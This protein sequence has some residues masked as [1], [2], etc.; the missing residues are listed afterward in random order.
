VKNSNTLSNLQPHQTFWT[1]RGI[2]RL[3]FFVKSDLARLFRDWAEDL[4]VHQMDAYSKN[5]S[6][7]DLPPYI[8]N[9]RYE[10]DT[11]VRRKVVNDVLWYK[12][13]DISLLCL[14]P[15]TSY[16]MKRLPSLDNFMKITP[17]FWNVAE[18]WCNEEGVKQFLKT[19]KT[20]NFI[21]LHDALFG[22]QSSLF[23]KG[24]EAD[25]GC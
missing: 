16:C 21:R 14:V 15:D 7:A 1:K 19:K 9:I 11:R 24:K 6:D 5:L 25:Y 22:Q 12:V 3:G 17:D 20:A 13:R 18:W 23:L 10:F 2:I 8:N 4:I